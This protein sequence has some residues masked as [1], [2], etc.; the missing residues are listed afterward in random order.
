MVF[1]HIHYNK[2]FEI[3]ASVKSTTPI[4]KVKSTTP[5][6]KVP[7]LVVPFLKPN[8]SGG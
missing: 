8:T 7:G 1:K 5:I 4:D 2:T 6:D 3:D